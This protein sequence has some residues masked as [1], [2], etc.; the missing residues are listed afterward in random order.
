[1]L[2]GLRFGR[3][4]FRSRPAARPVGPETALAVLDDQVP[5]EQAPPQHDRLAGELRVD[6]VDHAL[7]RDP[8]IAADLAPLRLAGEGAEP[9]PSAHRPEPAL[10]QAGEPVLAS[11]AASRAMW[12]GVVVQQ[13]APQPE[14]GL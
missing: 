5:V 12:L 2:E 6:L 9:F 1:M 8:G 3:V 10:G 14:I 11:R 4:L 7:D 13:V